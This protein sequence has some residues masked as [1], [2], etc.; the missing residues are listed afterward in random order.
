MLKTMSDGEV[1]KILLARALAQKTPIVF[2]DEPSS[3]LDLFNKAQLFQEIKHIVKKEKKTVV[4]SSHDLNTAIQICD[5]IIILLNNQW[6]Y[7]S[8]EELIEK[9]V[10][11][12]MFPKESVF[13]DPK[14]K[15][16]NICV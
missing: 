15:Q 4:F 2:L 1:Q 14:Q 5:Q 3:H 9:G 13:F 12:S 8:P 10:F 7:G 11:Q 16:F 6:E